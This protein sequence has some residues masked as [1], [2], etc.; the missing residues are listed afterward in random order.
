MERQLRAAIADEL[1]RASE[2][3][4]LVARISEADRHAIAQEV[5][6]RLEERLFPALAEPG[7]EPAPRR[8]R[9][10]RRGYFPGAGP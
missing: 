3:G 9:A 10:K 1:R 4:L 7:P 6:D 5:L 8:A 2:R